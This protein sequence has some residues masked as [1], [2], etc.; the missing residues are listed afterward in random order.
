VG[1]TEEAIGSGVSAGTTSVLAG[2]AVG[3][4]NG[5]VNALHAMDKIPKLSRNIADRFIGVSL[6]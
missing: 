3:D 1:G 5:V 6:R 2:I 4:W